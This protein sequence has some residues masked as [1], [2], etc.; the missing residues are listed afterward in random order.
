MPK[1]TRTRKT[2]KVPKKTSSKVKKDFNQF[3]HEIYKL[4]LT[5]LDKKDQIDARTELAIKLGAKSKSWVKPHIDLGALK[6]KSACN[7]ASGKAHQHSKVDSSSSTRA[8]ERG[9]KQ[10][11]LAFHQMQSSGKLSHK[12][13]HRD[14][15]PIL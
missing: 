1:P 7:G 6:S 14:T 9:N 12:T 5:G 11:T 13:S 2:R 10:N 15:N 8:S 3:R 4:G